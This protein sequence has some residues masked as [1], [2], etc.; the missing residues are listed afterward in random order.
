[1][2][3]FLFLGCT[4]SLGPDI[5]IVLDGSGSI[6]KPN[7]DLIKSFV[8][9]I[10]GSFDIGKA[11]SQAQV[12][13]I[14]YSTEVRREFDL[15]TYTNKSQVINAV[16]KIVYEGGGTNTHLAL[17]EMTNRAFTTT[18]GARPVSQ[19]HPRVGIVVTDGK[20]NDP[21]KTIAAALRAHN[22][23]LT[24]FAVGVGSSID[25]TELQVIAS[26]P[27]CTHL[28]LLSNFTE[29]DSLKYA[30]EKKTCEGSKLISSLLF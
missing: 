20:S 24:V 12:A 4:S 1:M 29:F 27:T 14:K 8:V 25:I 6:T 7:F 13:V 10:V 2:H 3:V 18:H 23:A 26:D 22:A 30:I 9:D 21:P 28:M 16:K 5:V 19:G 11:S 15:N 17:D